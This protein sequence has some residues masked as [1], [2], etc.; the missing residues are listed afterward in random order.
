MSN[1]ERKQQNALDNQ[2]QEYG[3]ATFRAMEVLLKLL[4]AHVDP[5][6]KVDNLLKRVE[7]CEKFLKH[8]FS[9]H[10]SPTSRIGNHCMQ[11]ALGSDIRA[12]DQ[13]QDPRPKARGYASACQHEHHKMC[14]ECEEPR[15]LLAEIDTLITT[16]GLSDK[17]RTLMRAECSHLGNKM[18]YYL[19]H[20]IRSKAED[21][22]R[23][24]V[25]AE[26]NPG[27]CCVVGDFKMKFRPNP[28]AEAHSEFFAKTGWPW[29]GLML[30]WM[31]NERQ[32]SYNYVNHISMVSKMTNA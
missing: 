29:H 26:M 23:A 2:A 28:H 8:D 18:E 5:P 21:G 3:D 13:A 10:L 30:M 16:A 7:Q 25:I 11:H 6:E 17:E 19:A 22:Q 1:S 32:I 14:L 31:D 15:L 12:E 4:A 9:D 20:L 24:K 27:D